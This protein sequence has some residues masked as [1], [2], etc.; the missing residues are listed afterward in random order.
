MRAY[1]PLVTIVMVGCLLS[2]ARADDREEARKEFTAGQDADKQKNW[3]TALEHYLRANELVPHPFAM[4]NIA[5][6]YERLSKLREAATWYQRYLDA[7]PEGNDR[8]KVQKTLGDLK[9]R[10]A[11]ITIRT[12]PDG[13]KVAI[14]GAPAGATPLST[15]I[16]GGVHKVTVEKD[17][18][19]DGRDV[20]VE[21]AEPVDVV[22]TLKGA[23][24]TLDIRGQ[25]F[26]ALVSVD[27]M[28][29]GTMPIKLTVA[30]GQHMVRVTQYGYVQFQAW[31]NVAP[32]QAT[33]VDINLVKGGMGA[34]PPPPT[35]GLD[36][37]Y[38]IGVNT[39]A[40]VKGAGGVVQ[41]ELGLRVNQFDVAFRVGAI[42]T[43]A[44]DGTAVDFLIRWAFSKS[45]FAP[46]IGAGYSYVDSSAGYEAVFG[47]KLD[48]AKGKGFG[49][50]ML[51]DIG[52]RYVSGQFNDTTFMTDDF[53]LFPLTVSL[54]AVYR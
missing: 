4:F 17:G 16:R 23:S 36:L 31:A 21:Y 10:P 35:I 24:G 2:V 8:D 9:N 22:F 20:T 27:N 29:A 40:D 54:Q 19:T 49:V 28:P 13:A 46:Y 1:L 11:P 42:G 53:T 45:T 12:I 43:P 33:P 38:F 50:S 39:G 32:N 30:P 48:I 41:G 52:A 6:D 34:L 18:Q 15:T 26:G 51:A 14:D 44:G 3:E 25:P 47:F 7:A 5:S 37:G